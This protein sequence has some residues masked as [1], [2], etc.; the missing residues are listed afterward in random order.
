[1]WKNIKYTEGPGGEVTD[2]AHK[3][4]SYTK[5]GSIVPASNRV[6]PDLPSDEQIHLAKVS[7][8]NTLMLNW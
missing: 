5:K 8:W 1:M 6:Y 3:H 2:L 4:L 7:G